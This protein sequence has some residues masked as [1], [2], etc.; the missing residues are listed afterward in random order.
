MP[1]IE[2][3]ALVPY[4]PQAMFDLVSAVDRYP[5]FLPW[6]ASSRILVQRDDGIDASLQV[7]FKGIQQQFSTRNLHQAPGLIRMQLLDG[8][9][10]RL[11]GS[12]HFDPLGD[13]GPKHHDTQPEAYDSDKGLRGT[14]VRLRLDYQMKSGLLAKLFSPAFDSIAA[15]MMDAFLARADQCYGK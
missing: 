11:E 10:E 12:W 15:Q 2:R 6:C 14:K 9:F 7:R 3:Q 5:Q 8:P 1:C 13:A 4:S